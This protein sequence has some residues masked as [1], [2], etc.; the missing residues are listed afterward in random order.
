[1]L[2]FFRVE[3]SKQVNYDLLK[4][5]KKKPAI[6]CGP[7]GLLD[8]FSE[9]EVDYMAGIS[10]QHALPYSKKNRPF[11]RE[12]NQI[13]MGP[14]GETDSLIKENFIFGCAGRHLINRYFPAKLRDIFHYHGFHVGIYSSEFVY[15][16]QY[17]SVMNIDK[18]FEYLGSMNLV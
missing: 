1:M 9:E 11:D 15:T 18:H 10:I 6:H 17:Q 8:L 14:E 3:H 7:W 16:S 4:Y 5:T 13:V 2:L 12:I